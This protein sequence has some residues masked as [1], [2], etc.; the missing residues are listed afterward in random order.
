[1]QNNVKTKVLV[2]CALMIALATVL[3]K[4]ELPLWAQGGS[5]TAASMLPIIMVSFRHGTKWGLLTAF[6]HSLLQLFLGFSNVLYCKTLGTQLLC[7]L[8]DYVLAFTA[9]GLACAIGSLAGSERM[10]IAFGVVSVCFIRFLCSFASGILLWGEYAPAGA[11]VWLHSLTY[12]GGYML[13]ETALT[14]AAALLLRRFM[15][16]QTA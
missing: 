13:P 11:P 4:I 16:R 2:E 8:L 12:N 15:Q 6:I 9:L 5:I 14:L 3:S 7:I 10:R 1:M